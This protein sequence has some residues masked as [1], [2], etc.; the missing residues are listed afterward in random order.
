VTEPREEWDV[1]SDVLSIDGVG[2]S[3]VDFIDLGRILQP[4][5]AVPV[6]IKSLVFQM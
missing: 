4:S 1:K 6:T 2:L 5:G 3:D